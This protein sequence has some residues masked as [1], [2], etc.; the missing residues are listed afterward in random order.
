MPGNRP[1]VLLRPSDPSYAERLVAFLAS[2]GLQASAEG[3]DAVRLARPL[4]ESEL[5]IYLRVWEVLHP[6]VGIEAEPEP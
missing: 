3:P 1:A 4:P 2:L 5:R 6:G